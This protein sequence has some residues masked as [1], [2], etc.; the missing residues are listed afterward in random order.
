MPAPRHA[1]PCE[2]LGEAGRGVGEL[3][4]VF[5]LNLEL[6]RANFG[7][8]RARHVNFIGP[9]GVVGK[10]GYYIAVP[11]LDKP[12]GNGEVLNLGAAPDHHFAGFEVSNQRQVIGQ[13]GNFTQLRGQRD[14]IRLH[15]KD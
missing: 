12:A 9:L 5:G 10:H 2:V 6:S 4:I 3:P 14:R 8:F 15:F 1:Q 11:D 13:H 7:R